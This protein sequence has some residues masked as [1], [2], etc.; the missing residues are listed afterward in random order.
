MNVFVENSRVFIALRCTL[1]FKNLE[2]LYLFV[3]LTVKQRFCLWWEVRICPWLT[4]FYDWV[5]KF[6]CFWKFVIMN[7]FIKSFLLFRQSR[8]T[9]CNWFPD[10]LPLLGLSWLSDRLRSWLFLLTCWLLSLFIVC[11]W[12]TSWWKFV[13]TSIACNFLL[14]QNLPFRFYLRAAHCQE[15][16]F[17]LY[18]TFTNTQI[19]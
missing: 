10:A 12:L 15:K 17:Y 16:N 2:F 5:N 6:F 19:H 8:L 4:L 3:Y 7:F 14:I 9:L 18:Q 13:R 11:N 1:P